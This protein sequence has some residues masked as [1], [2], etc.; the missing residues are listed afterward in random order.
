MACRAALLC[1][2]CVVLALCLATAASAATDLVLSAPEVRRIALASAPSM[3]SNE[4]TAGA[5]GL[6]QAKALGIPINTHFLVSVPA[7]AQVGFLL[8][9]P[10]TYW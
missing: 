10:T 4:R 5:T 2:C 7:A 3:E 8:P 6:Q 1:R 9:A